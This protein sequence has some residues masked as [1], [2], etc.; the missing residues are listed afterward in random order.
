M[1]AWHHVSRSS[2][3]LGQK[4]KPKLRSCSACSA[5]VSSRSS[6]QKP[7]LVSFWADVLTDAMLSSSKFFCSEAALAAD[8]KQSHV[9]NLEGSS[10]SAHYHQ[11]IQ[12]HF[13]PSPL[14]LELAALQGKH[15]K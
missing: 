14:Q 7:S 3:T 1:P 4:E 11:G 12:T 8:Q 5:D 13:S 9:I 15:Q 10:L 2:L 6:G